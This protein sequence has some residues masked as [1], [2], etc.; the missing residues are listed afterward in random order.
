MME[1]KATMK[2]LKLLFDYGNDEGYLQSTR[3][4][5][6]VIGDKDRFMQV[7]LNIIEN[8]IAFTFN[9][10]VSFSAKYNFKR[11]RLYLTCEDT[12]IGIELQKQELIFKTLNPIEHLNN[13]IN[14]QE[15]DDLSDPHSSQNMGL[16]LSICRDI[17]KMYDGIIS[18]ES[19]PY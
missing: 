8:A 9:G 3:I 7:A 17:L 2:N 16:G 15:A 6:E 11:N 1:T 4:P 13:L 10:Y 12:G 5:K 19:T 18:F 14:E